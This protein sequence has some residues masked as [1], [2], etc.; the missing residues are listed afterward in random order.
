MLWSANSTLRTLNLS[1]NRGIT[2]QGW[3]AFSAVL[4]YPRSALEELFIGKGLPI[5]NADS[6][7]TLVHSLS[8]NNKLKV[9][10]IGERTVLAKLAWTL[11]SPEVRVWAQLADLLCNKASILDTYKSNHT[12]QQLFTRDD[13]PR[14]DSEYSDNVYPL[15]QMNEAYTRCEAARRKVI[16]VHFGGDV[17]PHFMQMERKML[18]HA[19]AWMAKE[20]HS[21]A[22]SPKKNGL[23]SLHQFVQKVL[24]VVDLWKETSNGGN[25]RQRL[26]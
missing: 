5:I 10:R 22:D 11:R 3:R 7:V 13:P 12:L 9:L 1:G 14:V 16:M 17:V 19:I 8:T 18:P 26:N 15:L 25:K 2:A 6:A 24:F 23:P 4:K 21:D 20:C